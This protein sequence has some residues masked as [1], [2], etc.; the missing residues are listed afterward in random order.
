MMGVS[1]G[2]QKLQRMR[3]LDPRTETHKNSGFVDQTSSTSNRLEPHLKRWYA[4]DRG[5]LHGNL[6]SP[7]ALALA[8]PAPI[9]VS[10]IAAQLPRNDL[11]SRPLSCIICRRPPSSPT[12]SLSLRDDPRGVRRD[13]PLVRVHD[14]DDDDDDGGGDDDDESE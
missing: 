7:L 8:P 9:D 1:K 6:I 12:S 11:R 4:F 2:G 14:D 5:A 3:L 13:V 10:V